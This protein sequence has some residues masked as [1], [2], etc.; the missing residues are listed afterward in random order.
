MEVLCYWKPWRYGC[1]DFEQPKSCFFL[2]CLS[3]GQFYVPIFLLS[4]RM[5]DPIFCLDFI[6]KF[7]CLLVFPH[8]FLVLHWEVVTWAWQSSV[9]TASWILKPENSHHFKPHYEGMLPSLIYYIYIYLFVALKIDNF[10]LS[11]LNLKLWRWLYSRIFT[12]WYSSFFVKFKNAEGSGQVMREY[13]S[14]LSVWAQ[15]K[16]V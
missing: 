5:L 1:K 12:F 6:T 3:E 8:N 13:G 14:H 7:S 10:F 16:P 11:T 2:K 15:K 9:E 4:L